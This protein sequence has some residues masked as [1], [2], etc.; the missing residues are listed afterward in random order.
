MAGREQRQKARTKAITQR[1]DLLPSRITRAWRAL[2]VLMPDGYPSGGGEQVSGGGIGRPVEA[3]VLGREGMCD[4]RVSTQM[5]R[6]HDSGELVEVEVL[7]SRAMRVVDEQLGVIERAVAA[8]EAACT[9]M[10]APLVEKPAPAR[11]NMAD[12]RACGRTVANTPSDRLR[13]GY[14]N[15]CDKAWTRQGRPDRT[16]FERARMRQASAEDHS[17]QF[18]LDRDTA[19]VDVWAHGVQV[20]LEGELAA[21]F[22]ALQR[23]HGQ[24]PADDLSRLVEAAQSAAEARVVSSLAGA[25]DLLREE[26]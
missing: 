11:T 22:R 2:D 20:T 3:A 1:F 23:E 9:Q 4:S 16:Q 15:A 13:G 8:I 19:G 26:R 6:D 12:C 14:C 7:H 24:V 25:A 5:V 21:E 10:V 17:K 18:V